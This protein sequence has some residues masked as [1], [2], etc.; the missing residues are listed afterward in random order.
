MNTRLATKFLLASIVC[1]LS[2]YMPL[3][4]AQPEALT[5]TGDKIYGTV[6][7]TKDAGGYTYVQ[8]DTG[9]EKLWAAGPVTALSI[10]SMIAISTQMPM[11]NFQSKAFGRDF[12][13]IYFVPGFITDQAESQKSVMDPH[14]SIRQAKQ[15]PVSGIKK[16][17]NGNTIAEILEE[18]QA[19]NGKPIVVRGKVVKYNAEVLNKNWLHIAD[20]S[21]DKDLT[22][23][24]DSS[25]K[26]GDVVLVNGVLT[27][28]KDFG[29][30]YRYEVIIEDAEV[31][32]E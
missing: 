10:G 31:I 23:T 9:K 25:A 27:L 8:L 12:E 7:E 6:V 16:A 29:Y 18:Q 3:S 14:S 28:D 20:G 19:L 15:T 11:T 17:D 22:V 2:V 24:T 32:V 21:G 13:L 1:L 30:G 26:I 4:Q 5:N